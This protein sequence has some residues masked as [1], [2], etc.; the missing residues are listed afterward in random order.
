MASPMTFPNWQL[1]DHGGGELLITV[2]TFHSVFSSSHSDHVFITTC[3]QEG[4]EH[5]TNTIGIGQL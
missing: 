3:F 5:N 2:Y 1:G 4:I